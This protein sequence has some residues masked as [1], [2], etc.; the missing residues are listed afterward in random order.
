MKHPIYKITLILVLVASTLA[1]QAQFTVSG[2]VTDSRG[3]ALIGVT[4]AVANS[5]AGTVTDINGDYSIMISGTTAVL[6][7]SYVGHRS[8]AKDVNASSGPVNVS[9]EE[10]TSDLDEVIISGLATTIKRSNSA[11]SVS[12]V[13]ADELTGITTQSTLDGALYGKFS[14]VQIIANSGAPG[15][16]YN[17]RMR[18]VTSILGAAQPLFIIDGIYMDNSS[19]PAGINTVTGAAAGGNTAIYDQDNPTNR[20]ADL[21][22]GDIESIEILKGSS[23]AAIYGQRASGGVVIITTKRGKLT[24]PKKT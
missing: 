17:M 13:S 3:D 22:P 4:I 16:G 5:N 23:A 1:A 20:L 9:L 14:G 8:Q 24:L 12:E 18:G 15:G 2:N 7:F 6:T 10:T 21:D 19:I 11:N